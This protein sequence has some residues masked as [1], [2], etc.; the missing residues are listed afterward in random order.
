MDL[1]QAVLDLGTKIQTANEKT[2]Q[3][4]KKSRK[5][6]Y[7]FVAVI[8]VIV[9]IVLAVVAAQYGTSIHLSS[10]MTALQQAQQ[11]PPPQ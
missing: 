2:D 10:Q 11:A 6:M 4:I 1:F 8:L 9:I 7:A 5:G 3:D